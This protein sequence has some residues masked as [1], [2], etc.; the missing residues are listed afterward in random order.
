[1]SK[2][3]WAIVGA[4]GSLAGDPPTSHHTCSN[5]IGSSLLSHAICDDPQKFAPTIGHLEW[6]SAMEEEYYSLMKNHTWDLCT[7][8]K[9][10]KLVQY[11]WIYRTKFFA[12]GSIDKHKAH[13][14]VKS[15]LQ[16]EG[17]DYTETFAP[18]TKMNSI[19]LVLS[20]TTS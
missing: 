18:I 13:L 5:T 1:M 7:L 6:D 9:G 10:R 20:L 11:K 17:I 19:R 12:D 3:A 8:P 2:W 4:I 14:L 16:V 15:F